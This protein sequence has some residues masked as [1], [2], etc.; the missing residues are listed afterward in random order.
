MSQPSI[1][2]V[3]DELLIRDLLYDFFT[4]QGWSITVA[5]SGEKALELLRD[6]PVDLVL[7]D[8]KMPEMD[9]L[10]L[11]AELKESHPDL[12][13]VVMTGYPSVDSAVTALRTRVEDYV[14]KPFNINQLY[15]LVEATVRRSGT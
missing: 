12:P 4:G 13:I 11:A 5:E 1:M 6:K 14:I 2:V 15:K 9:G 7:T 10:Q 3:D 8:I